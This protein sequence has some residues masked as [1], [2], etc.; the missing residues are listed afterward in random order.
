[1]SWMSTHRWI[2]IVAAAAVVGLA[3]GCHTAQPIPESAFSEAGA[4]QHPQDGWIYQQLVSQKPTEPLPDDA[5]GVQQTSATEAMTKMREMDKVK[6]DD[7]PEEKSWFDLSSLSF[8][9]LGKSFKAAIGKGPNEGIARAAYRDG[10]ELFEQKKYDEA[11]AKFAE[12]S[13]RWPDTP[14]QEDALFMLGESYFF[15]DRY[16]YANDAYAQLL[17]QYQYTRHLDVVVRRLF[18]IGQFWE[19]TALAES[20]WDWLNFTD[21]SKPTIDTFGYSIKAYDAIRMNDPTGPLAADSIMAAGNAYFTRNR[22]EEAAYHYD[23]IR[24]EYPKSDHLVKAHVLGM[25]SK[26]NM[27]QGPF[28]D[29]AVL[30]DAGDIAKQAMTQLGPQ[31]GGEREYVVETRNKIGEEM[32]NRD[33][34]I[35]Q[36][37]EKKQCYGAAKYYYQVLLKDHPRSHMAQAAQQ[38]LEQTHAFPDDPPN[39]FKWLTDLFGTRK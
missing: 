26:M 30:K 5:S 28:Y 27:Y 17:K 9:N 12:A 16:P 18:L 38:R 8:S 39:P 10:L 24:K 29:D 21:K 35:A 13:D 20:S 34:T 36:F 11:A 32:A 6:L 25:K 14:L 2:A 22:F 23:L 4:A 31:L 33:W 19:K 15:A 37:Y 7:E 3:A 1:M